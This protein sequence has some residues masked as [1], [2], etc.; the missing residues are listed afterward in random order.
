MTQSTISPSQ[1]KLILQLLAG[2]VVGA[3]ASFSSHRWLE[4]LLTKDASAGAGAL[5]TVGLLYALMGLIVGLG[6]V[7]PAFGTRLL[8]VADRDDLSDQRAMLTGSAISCTA[9][10]LALAALA[11]T[12]PQGLVSGVWAVGALVF[13]LVVTALITIKQW[14][15]Y[16]ELMRGISLEAT[17]IMAGTAFPAIAVWAAVAH[18]GMTAPLD[19]LGVIALM[20]GSMLLGTFISAGRRGLLKPA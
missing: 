19:P 1:R 16:D 10:G 20:A 11:F 6:L 7:F 14:R 4:P 18:V 8:N 9:L 12:G 5:M 13:S 2:G 15:L 17:A 3:A